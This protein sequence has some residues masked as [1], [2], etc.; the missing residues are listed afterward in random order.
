MYSFIDVNERNETSEGFLPSEAFQINGEYLEHLVPGYRTL[1]VQGREALSPDVTSYETGTR[2]GSKLQNK[3]YPERILTVKYQMLATSNED[4]R[5]KYNLLGKVLNVTQAQ[6]IFDDEPDKYFIG[7]PCIIDAVTPGRNCVTGEFEILCTDPFKYSVVEYEAQATLDANSILIDYG[8]TYPAYPVLEADFYRPNG[9]ETLP[10]NAGD[11]GYVAFF[12]EDEQI[13]QLGD[14]EEIDGTTEQVSKTL[15]NQ[16]FEDPS[17]WDE[18][19]QAA[20][21]QNPSVSFLKGFQPMGALAMQQAAAMTVSTTD[22]T[23]GT[24]LKSAKSSAGSPIFYYTVTAKATART[25]TSVKVTAAIT[26]SLGASTSY[27][28]YGYGLRGSLYIGGAWHN[29][30]LKKTSAYWKGK[31]GHTVNLTVTVSG[32]SAGTASLSGIKFKVSRTDSL[33]NS[34]TL[35]EKTCAALPIPVYAVETSGEELLA[36]ADYGTAQSTWHGP[37]M[38]HTFAESAADFT[39]TLRQQMSIGKQSADKNQC[40]RFWALVLDEAGGCIAGIELMKNK[41]GNSGTLLCYA[42]ETAVYQKTVDLAYGNASLGSSGS[43]TITKSQDSITFSVCGVKKTVQSAALKTVGAKQ[44]VFAFAQYGST[45]PLA[46]NGL[47]WVKFVQN[48]CTML[49]NIPNKFG[50]ND[51][52]TANCMDGTI[53]LNGVQ[54]PELGAL[55]NDWETFTLT[56]GLNQIGFSYSD[57]VDLDYAPTMKVRYREVFL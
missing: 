18:A 12:T 48:N 5:E 2:D 45:A 4:F 14:P 24:L 9:E 46:Y 41:S 28:G 57:W 44:L 6:L 20:W 42:G 52:L 32:L 36:A 39:L 21:T 13:I 26:A 53:E 29:V 7:T 19:A 27:F 55:G 38:A 54:A 37:A 10:D 15:L 17:D 50:A 43:T 49:Q 3:R 35:S 33:G 30:T 23:S 51:V 8:G 56:P 47:F 1:T 40:G 16:T 31:S 25:E 34:G 11:C 22:S